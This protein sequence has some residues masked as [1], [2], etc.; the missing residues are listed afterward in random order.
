ERGKTYNKGDPN[1]YAPIIRQ[2][3][4]YPYNALQSQIEGF[5]IL[6]L[7]VKADG[8]TKNIKALFSNQK[9]FE[10]S[11]IKAIQKYKY[12]PRI[13]NGVAVDVED[14][15]VDLTFRMSS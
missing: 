13:V 10:N 2:A 4:K 15:L 7:T 1:E 9:M 6:S 12:R 11:A 14:I 5:V 8:T 3:P